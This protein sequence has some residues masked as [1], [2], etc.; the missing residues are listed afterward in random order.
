MSA[1]A[2]PRGRA[3]DHAL[4]RPGRDR[5]P[6]LHRAP[7]RDHRDHRPERRR[8]DHGV[9]LPDRLLPADRRPAHLPRHQRRRLLLEQMDGFRIP[10]DGLARTFQN[11]R[12]FAKMS[13]LE[14]LIVAAA[15]PADAGVRLQR[16]RPARRR[17]LPRMP[18]ARR[19]SSPGSGSTG[20]ASP[21][22]PTGTPAP[23]PT[24]TSASSRSR[25][26]CAPSRGC[27]A[28]TSPRPASTRARPPTCRSCCTSIRDEQGVVDPADRARHEHGDGHLRPHRRARLRP[29]DRRRPARRRSAATPD[30]DQGLS[31]RA[32][33]G[34]AAARGRGR[35]RRRGRSS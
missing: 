9:Q 29:E 22:R 8:Q 5:R 3:S 35:P 6:Q 23:C 34:G 4:R 12:L 26:P 16:A 2:A 14:N 7:A 10:R 31:R 17:R 30:G 32:R 27:F 20:P 13:A 15:Q 11:I 21:T 1:G 28:S 18:S 19:S 25:A 24:A 33:G